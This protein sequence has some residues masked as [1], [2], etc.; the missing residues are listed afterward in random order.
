MSKFNVASL[1]KRKDAPAPVIDQDRNTIL[2]VCTGNIARSA[3]AELIARHRDINDGWRF[4]SAGVGAVVGSGVAPDIDRELVHRG[5]NIR[6]Y[7]AKQMTRAL[8]EN[9]ALIVAMDSTHRQWLIRE[10]PQFHRKVVL[11]KQIQR[12]YAGGGEG[13]DALGY[14]T[15]LNLFEIPED[16]IA[17]P[18]RLGPQAAKKAVEEVEA[19]LD[20]LLPWLGTRNAPQA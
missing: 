1:L 6:G 15:T 11:L 13:N 2:F 20:I 18:F 4:D 19:G 5:I 16:S 7:R 9:A 8:A 10:F 3:S 14:L 17:D 12:A